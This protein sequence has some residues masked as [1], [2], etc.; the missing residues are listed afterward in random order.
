MEHVSGRLIALPHSSLEQLE[1]F[2]KKHAHCDVTKVSAAD[3]SS[4]CHDC[5]LMVLLL[6]CSNWISVYTLQAV[7]VSPCMH[8]PFMMNEEMHAWSKW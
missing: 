1:Q 5:V 7:A 8:L 6:I 4:T 3:V 2:L